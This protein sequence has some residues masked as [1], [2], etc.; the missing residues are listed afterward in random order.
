MRECG[1]LDLA[2]PFAALFTQG[3]I[4]HLTFKDAAGNWLEPGEVARD[5]AEVVGGRS[6]SRGR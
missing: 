5:E 1:Y 4:T 6:R 3:I 2:E